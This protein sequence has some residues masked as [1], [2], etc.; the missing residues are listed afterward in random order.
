MARRCTLSP[1]FAGTYSLRAPKKQTI[2]AV[3]QGGK[4]L[5]LTQQPDGTVSVKMEAGRSYR[6]TFG[7]LDSPISRFT[8]P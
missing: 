4:Q 1:D 8:N 6:V 3:T 5:P 2:T 7:D